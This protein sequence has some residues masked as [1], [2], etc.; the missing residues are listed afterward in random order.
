MKILSK[1]KEKGQ[2]HGTMK[3][4]KKKNRLLEEK[5]LASRTENK[6]LNSE[7]RKAR[8][9]KN[10]EL[11]KIGRVKILD[12]IKGMLIIN[13]EGKIEK[14]A[15]LFNKK[16]TTIDNL[17]LKFPTFEIKLYGEEYKI[18]TLQNFSELED[19]LIWKV[20]ELF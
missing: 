12:F 8:N 4:I 7:S 11:E 17:R 13:V 20:E 5:A 3:K 18:S 9:E 1:G 19:L 14:R 6:R 16:Y 15:L 2:K 10:L